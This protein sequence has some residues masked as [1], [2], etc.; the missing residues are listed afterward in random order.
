M[1]A[2]DAALVATRTA[3]RVGSVCVVNPAVGGFVHA[4]SYARQAR[5]AVPAACMRD[6][7]VSALAPV[8]ACRSRHVATCTAGHTT[9]GAV[10]AGQRHHGLRTG[11]VAR[12]P[13]DLAL[14]FT[15]WQG[16]PAVHQP[17]G[18]RHTAAP[19]T[20]ACPVVGR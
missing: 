20:G 19:P 12:R 7:A 5:P 13:A 2:A 1:A 6:R 18:R 17:R 9:T 4:V 14:R 3:V 16:I 11:R 8:D 15:F 10:L